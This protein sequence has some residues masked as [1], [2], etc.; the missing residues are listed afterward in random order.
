MVF[1]TTSTSTLLTIPRESRVRKKTPTRT[2]NSRDSEESFVVRS[3][4]S[5]RD[6]TGDEVKMIP[7]IR[8]R[9]QSL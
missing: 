8:K 1:E 6:D 4:K 3:S 2:A 9:V 7:P 5:D